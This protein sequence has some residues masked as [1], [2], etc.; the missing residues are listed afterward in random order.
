MSKTICLTG[1]QGNIGSTFLSFFKEKHSD[2]KVVCFNLLPFCLERIGEFLKNNKIDYFINCAALSR[3][4]DSF[5]KP[6]DFFQANVV[7]VFNQLEMIRLHSP[8]TRYITFG[9]IYEENH[10]SP[11]ASSKRLSREIVKTYRENYNLYA[12][13]ITL[14]HTEGKNHKKSFLAPKIAS[15]V[16]EICKSIISK[17]NY[18]P[19]EVIDADQKFYWADVEDV[20]EGAWLCLNQDTYSKVIPSVSQ[21]DLAKHIREYNL[22]AKE[23][24]S[25]KALVEL[26]FKAAKLE[27]LFTK[28]AGFSNLSYKWKSEEKEDKFVLGGQ[29]EDPNTQQTYFFN[30]HLATNKKSGGK[31]APPMRFLG[32]SEFAQNDLGWVLKSSFDKMIESMVL[33]NL[34]SLK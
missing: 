4:V 17:T 15:K 9:S 23:D 10:T 12:L 21:E 8:K 26:A 28:D 14:A 27:L 2:Y 33:F 16:A 19:I 34:T 30:L 32:G 31:I 1:A 25:I 24:H 5:A 3:D 13:Q 7:G 20:V 29:L 11:Y 18:A 22:F 6:Y